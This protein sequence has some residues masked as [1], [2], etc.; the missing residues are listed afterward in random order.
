MPINLDRINGPI[1]P[2]D[3]SFTPLLANLQGN[4]LKS[5][6][7][8]YTVNLFLTFED[9][10]QDQVKEW[11]GDFTRR[12]VT[13]ALRQMHESEEFKANGISGRLFASLS[14]SAK[15]Y[16]YLGFDL[17]AFREELNP[18]TAGIRFATGMAAAQSSLNDPDPAAWTVNTNEA[19]HAMILIADEAPLGT[20]TRL[21]QVLDRIKADL[22]PIASIEQVE[23]E[24]LRDE[25]NQPLEH[26]GYRDGISQPLFFEDEV[27]REREKYGIDAWDPSAAPSLVL[28]ADPLVEKEDSYGSYFVFRKL[29]QNVVGF[30]TLEKNLGF[31][32]R[33]GAMAVGR[34]ENG[35][36]LETAGSEQAVAFRNFNDF[37][38]HTDLKPPV[39]SPAQ[40]QPAQQ[41]QQAPPPPASLTPTESAGE[42]QE[43]ADGNTPV[44]PSIEY[45]RCPFH[46]HIRKTNPRGDTARVLFTQI[47]NPTPGQT[48]EQTDIQEREHRIARRGIT[49]GTRQLYR[50]EG[51]GTG[52]GG[53]LLEIKD[54]G[55]TSGFLPTDDEITAAGLTPR[56]PAGGVGLLFQCYQRSISNQFGFIQAAWANKPDF[57]AAGTGLDPIIGQAGAAGGPPQ[58]WA[59][60]Y[61]D[62]DQPRKEFAFGNVVTMQGGGFFF[63]PSLPFLLQFGTPSGAHLADMKEQAQAQVQ[64]PVQAL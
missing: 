49:F 42:T 25:M 28:V 14:L 32:A 2:T 4:I 11:I 21:Q 39:P 40:Q 58:E 45:R 44:P 15:G 6:G 29:E 26:F 3:P 31:G 48:T 47:P 52:G 22:K 56:H 54:K 13:S 17:D 33:G 60:V 35:I 50:R 61:N 16:A 30:K 63:T 20:G 55:D 57:P 38:Y 34:F 1:A 46:G 62:A 41:V 10:K 18:F 64:A 24:G 19:A 8:N 27:A 5:H 23:G 53:R 59:P 37:N 7:R 9:D 36:P 12:Y 43:D 51:S